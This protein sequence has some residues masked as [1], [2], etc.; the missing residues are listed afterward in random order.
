MNDLGSRCL[1]IENLILLIGHNPMPNYLVT[2]LLRPKC[3]HCLYTN[4][5]KDELIQIK[6]VL[7]AQMSDLEFQDYYLH[8]ATNPLEIRKSMKGIPPGAHLNYT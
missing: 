7:R 6:G 5:T 3:V 2:R 4:E 1:N 8:D